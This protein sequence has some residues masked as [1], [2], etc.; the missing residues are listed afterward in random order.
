M[1]HG[2][3]SERPGATLGAVR[4]SK[5]SFRG[6][7]MLAY[8]QYVLAHPEDSLHRTYHDKEYGF[9]LRDDNQLFERFMLEIN[10]AGLSWTTILKKADNFRRA[11]DGFN[12]AR[13]A[14]YAQPEIDRLLS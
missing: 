6:E 2:G 4:P 11:F 3:T 5:P 8:C 7:A 9:P 10:Q 13:V 12:V 14:A 1:P